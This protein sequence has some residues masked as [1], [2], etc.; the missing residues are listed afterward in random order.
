M[1]HKTTITL[2]ATTDLNFDQRL[3]RISS[4][5]QKN[6]YEV[7]L[8]GRLLKKS[9]VLNETRFNQHRIK[10]L[11][12]KGVLFYA[13][14]NLR[15]CFYMVFND[16][17]M[18]TA[19]DLDTVL[20]VYLG[21]LFSKETQ[22]VFDA[23]EYF[24]EVPE[25]QKTRFKKKVW[26]WVEQ[27]IV[28]KFNK[29]YTVNNS[30]ANIFKEN[31]NVD[32]GVLRNITET[33]KSKKRYKKNQERFILYQ[34]ALNKGRGLEALIKAVPK[35]KYPL[36]L[37]GDGDVKNE[38]LKLVTDLN[39]KDK[40]V[41]KGKLDP[42]E[43]RELTEQ[44]YIGVNLLENTSLN[45]YYSLANKFF[46]YVHAEIPQ[47]CMNFPEY[48]I[49]NKENEVAVLIKNLNEAAIVNA[50]KKL[51]NENFYKALKANCKPMKKE[52][53]WQNEEGKLLTIYN[54]INS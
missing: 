1:S 33:Y 6:G 46:D 7:T 11:F 36:V 10:C 54:S 15:I 32:F 4:S 21:S 13:E 27:K 18:V 14:F 38:L 3:Q 2:F 35:L 50:F 52:Y 40:V 17:E 12:N 16:S 41:F 37:A 19:N 47:V 43:L 53:H 28:P 5:L 30:L 45:Y 39:I 51:E 26:S 44:A 48:K 34:G 8:V 42:K 20:G 31:L 9:P 25:L 22:L 49:L 23:H 24:T 29:H